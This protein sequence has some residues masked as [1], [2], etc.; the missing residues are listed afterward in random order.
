MGRKAEGR[1]QFVVLGCFLFDLCH[2][3]NWSSLQACVPS[4]LSASV[5]S[6]SWLEQHQFAHPSQDQGI[7]K[8]VSISQRTLCYISSAMSIH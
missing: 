1:F 8:A 6:Q 4:C 3:L 5:S 2:V 7:I